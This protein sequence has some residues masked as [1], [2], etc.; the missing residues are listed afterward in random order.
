[1]SYFAISLDNSNSQGVIMNDEGDA[2][3]F[4]PRNSRKVWS[5]EKKEV[6]DYLEMMLIAMIMATIMKELVLVPA[7]KNLLTLPF[8][9][10]S[11]YLCCLC[12]SAE[13]G[14][15]DIDHGEDQEEHSAGGFPLQV[16]LPT[17]KSAL[18][19]GV[20]FTEKYHTCATWL[21]RQKGA[22]DKVK[23]P[24]GPLT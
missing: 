7:K 5:S 23:R 18:S 14:E 6:D 4:S 19:I 16:S 20:S 21:E 15:E 1:M 2:V 24:D 9:H 22:K 11:A 17:P 12:V 8:M 10:T 3:E 13:G